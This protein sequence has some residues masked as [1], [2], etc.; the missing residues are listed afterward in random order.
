M[1]AL[2][3]SLVL[4][5]GPAMSGSALSSQ[6][7]RSCPVTLPDRTVPPGAGFTAAG[8]NYGNARLRADLYWPRGTLSAGILPDGGAM[9]IVNFGWVD[10]GEARLVARHAAGAHS[11][12][13]QVRNHRTQA[14]RACPST[15]RRRSSVRIRSSGLHTHP[16][17]L[18]DSG[19]LACRRQAR[20]I[21]SDLRRERHQGQTESGLNFTSSSRDACRPPQA[22]L[23]N[24][25][26]TISLAEC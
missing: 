10:L 18:P 16:A 6:V 11:Q 15:A 26:A 9:A 25:L 14:R 3:L 13:A 12:P 2:A 8:F 1:T 17:N 19:L 21:T 22:D 4:A 5:V 23:R 7:R 24:Q 20:R